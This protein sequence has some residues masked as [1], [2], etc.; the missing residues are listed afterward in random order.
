MINPH[1]AE[2]IW[3]LLTFP[4][5]ELEAA[6][7]FSIFR[8]LRPS[9]RGALRWYAMGRVISL[10]Y[11]NID[12]GAPA[13]REWLASDV[14]DVGVLVG[15]GLLQPRAIKPRQREIFTD[16][17]IWVALTDVGC[18]VARLTATGQYMPDFLVNLG[19][20]DLPITDVRD[21]PFA[22]KTAEAPR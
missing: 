6:A 5:D 9:A 2:Q 14:S 10:L 3:S 17:D 11:P 15:R 7:S 18:R 21:S 19:L 13:D 4:S 20:R 12:E 1:T 16:S 8:D 22:L